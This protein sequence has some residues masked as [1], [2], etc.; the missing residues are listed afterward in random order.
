MHTRKSS[1][2]VH[3]SAY[4]FLLAQL[5]LDSLIGKRSVKAVR[6]ALSRLP[7]G[8]GAYDRAYDDAMERIEAQVADQT[9][10]AKQVLSWIT[11]ARR[12]LKTVELQYALATEIDEPALDPDNISEIDDI[13]SAC[14]GLV[15]IDDESGIIRLV[16]YTTQEYLD[17]TKDRWFP[18]AEED[19]LA[20]CI[21][22]LNFAAFDDK[23]RNFHV[24]SEAF[25]GEYPL[26]NYASTYW[27][28]HS[29]G[30]P[31]TEAM[32][33]FLMTPQKAQLS[34]QD[35][36][37]PFLPIVR[38]V[39]GPHLL[40]WFGLARP[41]KALIDRGCDFNQIDWKAQSPLHWAAERGATAVI[42]ELI[43]Q[44]GDDLEVDLGDRIGRTPFIYAA[45]HGHEAVVMLLLQQ[46]RVR[47]NRR[48][49]YGKTAFYLAV[50]RGHTS[51]VHKLIANDTI[52][53]DTED[54]IG[55][56]PLALAA[57][58]DH[59]DIVKLL[60]ASGRPDVNPTA[61]TRSPTPLWFAAG[62]GR[63]D[64]IECLLAARARVDSYEDTGGQTPLS[65]ALR[66][67][68]DDAA[69]ILLHHGADATKCDEE[70]R[71]ML[72]HAL[73]REGPRRGPWWATN[74]PSCSL[75]TVE[76]LIRS[77]APLDTLDTNNMSPMLY[78]VD[79]ERE[80]VAELLLQHGMNVNAAVTRMIQERILWPTSTASEDSDEDALSTF[81]TTGAPAGM[82]QLTQ[83][84]TPLHLAALVGIPKMVT[85]LLSHGADPG[86]RTSDGQ[87][88]LHLAICGDLRLGED[89][90]DRWA[91]VLQRIENQGPLREECEDDGTY[92]D[93]VIQ[94]YRSAIEQRLEV[95]KALL[96]HPGTDVRGQD[97][98][99][100]S[101][102]HCA[103][104]PLLVPW[105]ISDSRDLRDRRWW[106]P[107]R[108]F[109]LF[110]TGLMLK[111]SG[112]Q[113]M[114]HFVERTHVVVK[115]LIDRGADVSAVDMDNRTA[116]HLACLYG[117]LPTISV[118]LAH[119]ADPLLKDQDGHNALQCAAIGGNCAA[120]AR[121]L[122]TGG[123]RPWD[124]SKTVDGHGRTPLHHL[125][126]GRRADV[127]TTRVLIEAGCDIK[128]QDSAG[129]TPL[130]VYLGYD[131]GYQ[132]SFK[133]LPYLPVDPGVCQLLT[134]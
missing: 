36:R 30:A 101:P 67:A 53:V 79:A 20:V 134:P 46:Q 109:T 102:L 51:L 17:R 40:A 63:V 22:S 1:K 71:S 50:D 96:D 10:L 54:E 33:T 114:V 93:Q 125:C 129:Q 6:L 123:L 62:A 82:K 88:P 27:A 87:M 111:D 98:T 25:L 35:M 13:M 45:S 38:G 91:D 21:T 42:E 76:L 70:L 131:Y 97:A 44:L 29:R 133:N 69:R 95:I 56:R 74:P 8:S 55:R 49:K 5:H 3:S 15:T 57:S 12:P 75:R 14:L 94:A 52:E 18:R 124:L 107:D 66:M 104:V 60:V 122:Q 85:F 19:V 120:V 4:R 59:F 72:H 108:A 73:R 16:H 83:E 118:L 90:D 41:I 48:D 99:G 113:L 100:A 89:I 65:Y 106:L 112:R 105:L 110:T 92:P 28:E 130:D 61:P 37:R 77:G 68:H 23:A 132:A 78:A 43:T 39:S 121:I 126:W 119:G 7:T 26:H 115:M 128:R 32:L 24:R 103:L 117:E 11:L 2:P 86:L 34:H 58:L 31:V 80:D 9:E 47:P 64:V 84:L 127:E 116:L 81:D